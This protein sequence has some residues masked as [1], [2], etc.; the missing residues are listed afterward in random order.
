MTTD[1][2]RD[3]SGRIFRRHNRVTSRLMLAPPTDD[4]SGES[5]RRRIEKAESRMNEA[6]SS[7]N[8]I[9]AA[10][11]SGREV[12]FELENRVRRTVR[13]CA[14]STR[15]LETLLDEHGIGSKTPGAFEP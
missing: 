7:L 10:R 15:R 13:T 5:A 4:E 1:E 8:E 2:L 9:A 11:A 6:C 12:D 14:E 3:Y